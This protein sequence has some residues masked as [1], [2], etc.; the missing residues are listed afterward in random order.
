MSPETSQ[1]LS[2]QAFVQQ[3][4]SDSANGIETEIANRVEAQTPVELLQDQERFQQVAQERDIGLVARVESVDSVRSAV[5]LAQEATGS[6]PGEA[7]IFSSADIIG[8]QK[9]KLTG[10]IE[11]RLAKY[12]ETPEGA[13]DVEIG[14][15]KRII[16][17]TE[18]VGR[19]EAIRSAK[20]V[21]IKIPLRQRVRP[22]GGV[23][24]ITSHAQAAAK[25]KLRAMG[26]IHESGFDD[27][28]ETVEDISRDATLQA[29]GLVELIVRDYDDSL[30]SVRR[31]ISDREQV[32]PLRPIST[33]AV[34]GETIGEM[35]HK[36]VE[37]KRECREAFE[38]GD[39]SLILSAVLRGDISIESVLEEA[40]STARDKVGFGDA[41]DTV[42]AGISQGVR[43]ELGTPSLLAEQFGEAQVSALEH[44]EGS[45]RSLQ[46]MVGRPKV[47]ETWLTDVVNDVQEAQNGL[48]VMSDEASTLYWHFTAEGERVIE[49]GGLTPQTEAKDKNT[50]DHSQGVHFVKPG[51][52]SHVELTGHDRYVTYSKRRPGK[53]RESEALGVAVVFPLADIIKQTPLRSEQKIVTDEG[54]HVSKDTVFATPEQGLDYKYDLRDAYLVAQTDQDREKLI[55]ELTAQG[56]EQA[57][58]D[59][60]VILDIYGE[61]EIAQQR[62]GSISATIEQRAKARLTGKIVPL[63]AKPGSIEH[64]DTPDV[65]T[66]SSY[67]SRE[68][69]VEYLGQIAA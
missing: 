59:E 55:E 46:Q 65:S 7:L 18:V 14:Q 31:R 52:F 37:S 57:W 9:D 6:K 56:Y 2:E 26:V 8:G 28:E 63:S 40:R 48:E 62:L 20:E 21:G 38:T 23:E 19:R 33:Q 29:R 30:D 11:G 24:K 15:L 3:G 61:G 16:A 12:S 10:I 17:G 51:D 60:H 13:R 35:T 32:S 27:G 5:S 68:S 69:Y 67:F 50:G 25:K 58:I 66:G 34:V 47:A 39:T 36:H 1:P 22:R 54:Q 53:E 44:L 49:S 45:M 64:T 4:Y 41:I 43:A 42:V